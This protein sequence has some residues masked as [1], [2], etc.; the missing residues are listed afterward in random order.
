MLSL[1]SPLS[2]VHLTFQSRARWVSYIPLSVYVFPVIGDNLTFQSRARWVSY[3]PLSVYVFPVIGDNLTF[4][5]RALLVRMMPYPTKQPK[6]AGASLGS[7]DKRFGKEVNRL[8][9]CIR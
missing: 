4:Q 2:L 7:K 9:R 5:S 6:P 1:T 3:I 8:R